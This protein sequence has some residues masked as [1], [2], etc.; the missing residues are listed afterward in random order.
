MADDPAT[1]STE[2]VVTFTAWHEA[3]T[4]QPWLTR[5]TLE[6]RRASLDGTEYRWEFTVSDTST[7]DDREDGGLR[8]AVFEDGLAAFADIPEFFAALSAER[9]THLPEVAAILH[10]LGIADVTVREVPAR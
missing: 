10:G 9:P 3:C 2:T 4:A 8:I 5:P 1:D 7:E 6:I